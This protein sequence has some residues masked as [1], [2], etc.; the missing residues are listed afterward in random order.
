MSSIE[1]ALQAPC[2]TCA[3]RRL[4]EDAADLIRRSLFAWARGLERP[5]C[6]FFREAR[7]HGVEG[8]SPAPPTSPRCHATVC[9]G[10]V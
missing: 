10:C 7:W 8:V 2:A 9:R 1:S 4:C 5:V 6:E 3:D